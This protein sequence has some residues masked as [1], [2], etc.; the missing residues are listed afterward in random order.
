MLDSILEIDFQLF[1]LINQSF[2]NNFF[3]F[4]MPY[5]REKTVWIPLYIGL[6]VFFIK[7]FKLKKGIIIIV[8][9]IICVGISD[10]TSSKII[11]PNV[12]RLRPCNTEQ[13]VR[14]LVNCGSGYSFTSSHAANH[15][16]L[17]TFW[18]LILGHFK[19]SRYLFLLWAASISFAQ[20][21]VGVHYPLDILSGAILGSI[22]AFSMYLLHSKTSIYKENSL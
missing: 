9:S 3:D 14:L 7:Q 10:I 11:K 8:L 17:G 12:E 1:E 13:E 19:R 2:Q 18:F 21:Y 5:L 22:I 6:A 15:F 4:I 16:A 20:V